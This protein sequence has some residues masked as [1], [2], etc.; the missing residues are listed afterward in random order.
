MPGP[1]EYSTNYIEEKNAKFA[2]GKRFSMP[3]DKRDCDHKDPRVV[4]EI[5]IGTAHLSQPSR[6]TRSYVNINS[7]KDGD[8]QLRRP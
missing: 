3:K 2:T 4:K 5:H 8:D 1:G 6:A 7:A